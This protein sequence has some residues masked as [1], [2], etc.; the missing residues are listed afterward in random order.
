MELAGRTLAITGAGGFIGA[1]CASLA[2]ARGMRVRGLDLDPAA[3]R[4]AQA[5]GIDARVG[6]VTDAEAVRW[7]CEG[8]DVVLHT[9]AVVLEDGP[10]EIFDRVNVL[11]TR[12]VADAAAAARVPCFVHLS[13]VMVYGFDFPDGVTEDGP[14]PARETNPYCVTKLRSEGAAMRAHGGS[15]R[16]VVVRPGDVYG[17][18]SIPW[19]VRPLE[20][21][22]QHLFVLPDGGLGIFNHV[23]VDDL[24]EAILLAAE[25]DV[26]GLP[27][28]VCDGVRTTFRDYFGRLAAHAGLPAPRSLPSALLRPAFAALATA[29]RAAGRR[30][31]AAPAALDFLRRPNVYSNA[32][33]RTLLGWSS[34]V[35]LA[36]G[37]A[38]LTPD[39]RG[40]LAP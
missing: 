15:T 7:L 31:P 37:I 11:G 24:A 14:Y 34:K 13:S 18:G 6:D 38:R 39:G 5:S 19:V 21:M 30:A 35:D 4:R 1:R 33:A 16:V 29:Y 10:M 20:L 28:N 17:A 27:I 2:Q 9:A 25:R 26:G 23:H 32:R 8:A 3:A 40:E 36:A 22:R 12:M